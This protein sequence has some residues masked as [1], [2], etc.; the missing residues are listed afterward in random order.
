MKPCLA[1]TLVELDKYRWKIDIGVRRQSFSLSK[2]FILGVPQKSL[3]AFFLALN[4]QKYKGRGFSL[5]I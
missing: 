3:F 2:V 1:L 4:M 5:E